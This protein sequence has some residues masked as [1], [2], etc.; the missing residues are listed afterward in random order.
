MAIIQKLIFEKAGDSTFNAQS[1]KTI[2]ESAAHYVAVGHGLREVS[3][4][5][6]QAVKEEFGK[7]T[8]TRNW[9]SETAYKAYKVKMSALNDQHRADIRAKGVDVTVTEDVMP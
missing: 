8:Y 6:T 2:I 5:F 4:S 3:N 1:L 9:K 7:V